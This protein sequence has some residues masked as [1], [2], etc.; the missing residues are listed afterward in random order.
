MLQI[1]EQKNRHFQ[2]KS[3]LLKSASG[4]LGLDTMLHPCLQRSDFLAAVTYCSIPLFDQEPSIPKFFHMYHTEKIEH[5]N[6]H[7][8]QLGDSR[9]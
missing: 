1:N 8:Q 2:M 7:T 4:C 5:I 3:T 6:S 9:A